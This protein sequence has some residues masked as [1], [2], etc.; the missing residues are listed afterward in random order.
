MK[1]G[2]QEWLF[3]EVGESI[4]E[5]KLHEIGKKVSEDE[6]HQAPN[7]VMDEQARKELPSWPME[8]SSRRIVINKPFTHFTELEPDVIFNSKDSNGN[9]TKIEFQMQENNNVK[10]TFF[11]KSGEVRSLHLILEKNG[12][13][14]Q[15]F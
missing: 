13:I 2:K 4:E 3:P 11:L 7:I 12:Q 8:I 15:T 14:R 9:I 1:E 6:I 10:V 5:Y